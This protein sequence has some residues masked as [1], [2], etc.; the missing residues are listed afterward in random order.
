MISHKHEFIFIHAPRT[1]GSSIESQFDFSFRRDKEGSKHWTL[2]DWQKRLDPEIFDD[3]FKF[4]FVRNSWDFTISKYKSAWFCRIG[5]KTG[6]SL[7]YFLNHYQKPKHEH[8]E[9]FFEYFDP[10][11]MDYIGRFE[12]RENDL[13]FI[14]ERIGVALDVEIHMQK[15]QAQGKYKHYTEYYDDETR[16]IVAQKYARDIEYFGY[17]FG[18]EQ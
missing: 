9:T 4:G 12:D 2:S 10:E 13:N 3:Y 17:K 8:G 18:G 14:S 15:V 7:K 6:K 11:K 5:E 1:G 16:E